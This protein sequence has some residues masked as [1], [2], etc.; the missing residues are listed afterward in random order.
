MPSALS[1]ITGLLRRW[2][3]GDVGA[4]DQL[5]PIVY[6][7][8]RQL[9]RARAAMASVPLASD[10]VAGTA[11]MGDAAEIY[12]RAGD[13]DNAIA[14]LGQ[15]LGMAAGREMSVPLLR[16]DP[17]WDPLQADARFARMVG[18]SARP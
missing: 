15:L 11:I 12:T 3:E 8:L 5:V 4:F 18:G 2:A 13:H 9:A 16:I 6:D 10:V 7:R 14:L 1:Q 17:R